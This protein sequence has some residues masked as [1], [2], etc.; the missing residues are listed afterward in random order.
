MLLDQYKFIRTWL[1][2]TNCLYVDKNLVLII[3][4]TLK[5]DDQ[6]LCYCGEVFQLS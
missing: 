6:S 2:V 5:I 4:Y 3:V 1:P